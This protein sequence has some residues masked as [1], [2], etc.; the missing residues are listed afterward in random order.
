[1]KKFLVLFVILSI[2]FTLATVCFADEETT[3]I[4]NELTPMSSPETSTT[5]T[6]DDPEREI[7]I[8]ETPAGAPETGSQE[9]RDLSAEAVPA[10]GKLAETGG[11]AAEVFYAAGGLFI[12]AAGVLAA[13]RKK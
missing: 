1:M 2:I 4:D 11:V 7:E 8:E 12:V 13:A 9:E 6:Y 3:D 5:A 10:S